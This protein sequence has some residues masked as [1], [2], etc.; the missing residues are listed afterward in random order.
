M[1]HTHEM[2]NK[3]RATRSTY[4]SRH[5]W[6]NHDHVFRTY[7]PEYFFSRPP[8]LSTSQMVSLVPPTS[9]RSIAPSQKLPQVFYHPTPHSFVIH[10]G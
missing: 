4:E 5:N 9:A 2:H 7:S 3:V 8:P 6:D 1:V 10:F